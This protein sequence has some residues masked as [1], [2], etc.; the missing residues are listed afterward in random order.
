LERHLNYFYT[1]LRTLPDNNQVL[2]DC[3][4]NS[5]V[6]TIYT[7]NCGVWV[8]CSYQIDPNAEVRKDYGYQGDCPSPV[9]YNGASYIDLWKYQSCGT[10]CCKKTYTLCIDKTEGI[11][12]INDVQRTRITQDEN[13]TLQG[14]FI[15]WRA[16]YEEYQCQDGCGSDGN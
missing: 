12:Q 5:P 8:K 16:P 11:V 9:S 13:C 6:V 7:A 4:D 2:P 1:N 3:P 14:N 15:N 10:I